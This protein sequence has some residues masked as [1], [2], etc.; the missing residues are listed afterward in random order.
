MRDVGIVL[1]PTRDTR[2]RQ[3]MWHKE[4]DA[5]GL[6]DHLGAFEPARGAYFVVGCVLLRHT[7]SV[8][9][10]ICHKTPAKRLS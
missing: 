1:A 8:A 10:R 5:A 7:L 6:K 2:T 4:A 3:R 9:M